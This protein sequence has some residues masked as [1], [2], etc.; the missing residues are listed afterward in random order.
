MRDLL[1]SIKHEWHPPTLLVI[2]GALLLV[3]W[4]SYDPLDLKRAPGGRPV[5]AHITSL[6]PL[7]NRYQGRWPGLRVSARTDDGIAGIITALPVD[8]AGC[9]VGDRIDAQQVGMKL[10]LTPRP[11]K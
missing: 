2:I 8:L 3:A 5:E 6:S 11:C 4:L 9:E 7:G 1:F 10:Y